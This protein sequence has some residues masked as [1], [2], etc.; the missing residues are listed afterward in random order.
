MKISTNNKNLF[1]MKKSM[2]LRSLAIVAIAMLAVSAFAQPTFTVFQNDVKTYTVPVLA[3]HAP[4]ASITHHWSVTGGTSTVI[5]G[6][7]TNAVTVTWNGAPGTYTLSVYPELTC[8][9]NDAPHTQ[10]ASITILPTTSDITFGA[11]VAATRCANGNFNL[12][13]TASFN[14]VAG[15]TY[16]VQCTVAGGPATTYAITPT[17]ATVNGTIALTIPN[18]GAANITPNIVITNIRTNGGSWV[19]VAG[20]GHT[21]SNQTITPEPMLDTIF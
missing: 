20:A 18:T 17:F 13:V 1:F 5:T 14:F 4:S 16:D 3:G 2:F 11:N 9:F 19:A 15:N 12:N 8:T 21:V 6:V 10:T 7:T